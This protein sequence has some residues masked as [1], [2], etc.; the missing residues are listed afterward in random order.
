MA[1]VSS[2][3]ALAISTPSVQAG[4]VTATPQRALHAVHLTAPA[5][6]SRKY[7]A[8]LEA[9]LTSTI[10]NSIVVDMKDED[11]FVYVP[12]VKIAQR[13]GAYAAVV[14]DLQTWLA[15]LKKRGIYT[16]ARIVVFKDNRAPRANKS[17]GV[18]NLYGDLWY[19]RRKGTWLDPYNTESWRYNLLVALQAARCG[20]DE[21]Q[22]DYIRFPTDGNLA[23]SRF[24]RPFSRSTAPQALVR[25]L[26]EAAQ[27]L[28]PLGAKIS[29]DL[30]GLTTSVSTGM[31][32][33][34]KL[35]VMAEPV[36]YV[37]PMTYPSHYA[38]GEYG[39]P[40]PNDEPYKTV[41][42]AMRDALR[43]LGPEG[44]RKLRPYLQDFSLKGRGIPYRAKEVRA[45]IQAALDEGIANWTLW[46]ANSHYTLEALR[47]PFFPALPA[48][49]TAAVLS[50]E[51]STTPVV[52]KT[53]SK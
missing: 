27:L 48:G 37:C 33:G 10:V 26:E 4:S 29:I 24:S 45:Q 16:V 43:L 17:W 21:V 6:G 22:F 8:K 44:A 20:F 49:T 1:S 28:H 52:G 50:V 25:F 32:I 47:N 11:G 2:S 40:N 3:T 36:D 7:R 41:H 51:P 14:P 31:G 15:D 18:H 39:I 35:T 30:F 13:S 5:A 34:Q 42:L 23:T 53:D 9:M 38:R 19:D 12:G 46:N